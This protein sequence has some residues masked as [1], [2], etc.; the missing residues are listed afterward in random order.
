M[1]TLERR[2]VSLEA[3]ALGS[4]VQL[5]PLRRI[6]SPA[7]PAAEMMVADI[8]G[9]QHRRGLDEAEADFIERLE[10]I[11]RAAWKAGGP[12]RIICS[13]ADVEL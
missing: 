3:A 13:L 8:A 12:V 9:E 2:L 10:G 7:D 1:N 6:V 5:I 4:G 11:A